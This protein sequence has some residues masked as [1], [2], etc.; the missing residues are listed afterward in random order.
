MIQRVPRAWAEVRQE[1]LEL[2][3]LHPRQPLR[4]VR[5][6]V[7]CGGGGHGMGRRVSEGP[8]VLNTPLHT[9]SVWPAKKGSDGACPLRFFG[10]PRE[11]W[12]V[13]SR[14]PAR[15]GVDS[16]STTTSPYLANPS[17][18]RRFKR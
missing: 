3:D 4:G 12:C 6:Q 17:D 10:V 14:N 11:T 7:N 18:V 13:A 9:L 1:A 16:G 5:R 15:L 2:R 8:W